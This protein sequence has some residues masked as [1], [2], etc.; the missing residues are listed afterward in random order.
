MSI[1]MSINPTI[2]GNKVAIFEAVLEF[3]IPLKPLICS[4]SSSSKQSETDNCLT[5]RG[6]KVLHQQE[7]KNIC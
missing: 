1:I 6:N 2:K 5:L 4:L 3:L 7:Q